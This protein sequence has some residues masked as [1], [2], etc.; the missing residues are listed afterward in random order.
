[1]KY[2]QMLI[3]AILVSLVGCATASRMNRLSVGM[4]KQEVCSALGNPDS[5]ASPG[6]GIDI[7][8]YELTTKERPYGRISREYYVKLVDGKVESFGKMGD[9]DSTKDPTLNLNIKN[10]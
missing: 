4:T 1:M 5:S 9:F 7:L 3:I 8:R 6:G 2:T 10:R